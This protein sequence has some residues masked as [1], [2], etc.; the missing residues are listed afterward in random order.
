MARITLVH[1]RLLLIFSK[2]RQ[3]G[4]PSRLNPR[5]RVS[6]VQGRGQYVDFGE[7]GSAEGHG[8]SINPC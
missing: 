6:F 7:A 1:A 8:I 5:R 3:V 2:V 4:W